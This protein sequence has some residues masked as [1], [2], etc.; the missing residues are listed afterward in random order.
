MYFQ[1]NCIL[2]YCKSTLAGI[3]YLSLAVCP[4]AIAQSSAISASHLKL[5]FSLVVANTTTQTPTLNQNII[6][7][8]D[9]LVGAKIGKG[10]CME[11]VIKVLEDNKAEGRKIVN[12]FPDK[13]DTIY[14][15]DIIVFSCIRFKYP[16]GRKELVR[17]HIAIIYKVL[18]PL[19]YIIAH[20]N[21]SG[22]LKYSHVGF[23]EINLNH[24]IRRGKIR[25]WIE[26][27]RPVLQTT[28]I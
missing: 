18:G 4:N 9:I 2:S 10:M 8:I 14:P 1:N 12:W 6:D 25:S 22:K 28:I 27:H 16:D 24:G 11:F 13:Q 20:Q 3:F 15:G 5:Y 23:E 19:N 7:D 17:G 21:F 26:I